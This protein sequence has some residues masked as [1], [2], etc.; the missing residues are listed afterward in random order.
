MQEKMKAGGMTLHPEGH[1][2]PPGGCPGKAMRTFNRTGGPGSVPAEVKKADTEVGASVNFIVLHFCAGL[3]QLRRLAKMAPLPLRLM[4]RAVE[5]INMLRSALILSVGL[6]P[7]PRTLGKPQETCL[8]SGFGAAPQLENR[9]VENQL[10][11]LGLC[12]AKAER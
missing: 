8:H 11:V 4:L 9:L 6:R 10:V 12:E 7:T 1:T 5:P 3:C 2:P